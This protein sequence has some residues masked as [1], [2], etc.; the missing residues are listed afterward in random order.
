MLAPAQTLVTY[1]P[2]GYLLFVRDKTL[3]AQPFDAKAHE[4][5]GRAGAA[6]RKDRHRQR[7]AR[8]LLGVARRRRSPTARESR[9]AGCSG[10]T[11][12][13]KELETVGRSGRLREP[14]PLSGRR[15][16]RLQPRRSRE[17]GKTTSGSAISRAASTPASRLGAGNNIRPVWSP[18]GGTIVFSSD[19]DGSARSLREV[20]AAARA[21]RSCCSRA[22]SPSPHP[23][24]RRDGR[25]IAYASQNP[26]TSWDI[27]ALPTFGDRKPFPIVVAPFSRVQPMFSPDGRFVAYVSN[28]SGRAEIYVQTFPDGGGKWQVSNAGG[29]D[30]SWRGDGKE[31]YYRSPGPEAHGGRDPAAEATSR[32]ASRSRSFPVARPAGHRA[33]QV[34]AVAPTASGSSSSRRSAARP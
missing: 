15:P 23:A 22:T 10:G 21:R 3:V 28:E 33:Q 26:K 1:A 12:R 5:D 9:A 18:D 14:G 29:I 31:L 30:P 11:A 16:A 2:P 25:Y 13:D 34:R 19:R 27:W 6:G 32:R 8:A 4:D 24:G 17:A 20:D 7:R